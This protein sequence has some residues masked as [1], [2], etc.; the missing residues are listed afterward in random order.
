MEA[1]CSD[2][3]QVLQRRGLLKDFSEEPDDFQV[4]PVFVKSAELL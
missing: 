1:C 4:A 2:L 3:E